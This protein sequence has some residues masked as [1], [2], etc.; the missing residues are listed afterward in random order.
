MTKVPQEER[1]VTLGV[2]THADIH[3][4]VALD[5]L[6]GMLGAIEI[7][8][9]RAGCA[10]LLEWASALGVIDRV[11]IEGTGSYGAGLF[12]WLR[13]R[14]ITVVEVDRPD[15]KLRRQRG[16]DDITDAEGAARSVLSGQATGI[17]KS[18]DG[19]VEMIRVLRVARRSA[20]RA[21]IAAINQLHA[22]VVSA[23]D[24]LREAFAGMTALGKVRKAAA[25][26]PGPS[27]TTVEAA[28]KLALKKLAH[29]YLELVEEIAELD[30]HIARLV[31]QTAPAL[32]A[33]P[34]IGVQCAAQLLV[35]AGDNPQR[36]HS[37]G[38]FAHLCGVAPVPA[39]SG[40][41]ADRHRLNKGGDRDANCALHMIAVNR[42]SRCERTRAYVNKRSPDGKA[43]LDILR[44]LK[45]YI[46]REVYKILTEDV[47]ATALE[48]A[49]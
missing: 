43:D 22:L 24:E 31:E 47:P 26:R 18:A 9:T 20:M 19:N 48:R 38:S 11:G 40:K 41:R 8:T 25:L 35:T 15:R 46:A 10:Q 28:T 4:A 36:L 49:A 42:L 3:V 13:A 14:G 32:L 16:K 34:G 39:S 27:V 5:Q 1:L 21:K 12:R 33:Q 37:E 6:G 2:D 23:P 45:R 7:P 29:R 44:R 17:P 30:T